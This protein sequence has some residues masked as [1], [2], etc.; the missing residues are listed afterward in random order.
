MFKNM[1]KI[2]IKFIIWLDRIQKGRFNKFEIRGCKD[3]QFY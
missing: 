1:N 2:G 3:L